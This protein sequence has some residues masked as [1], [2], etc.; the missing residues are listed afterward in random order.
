MKKMRRWGMEGNSATCYLGNG[1]TQDEW[2]LIPLET[3]FTIIHQR[4][5]TL[6]EQAKAHD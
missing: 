4:R 2:R 1:P 3:S 5:R 6:L